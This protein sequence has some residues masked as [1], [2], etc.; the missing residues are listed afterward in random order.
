[1]QVVSESSVDIFVV[2]L[3]LIPQICIID[4]FY[5]GLVW[6]FFF[7]FHISANNPLFVFYC[8]CVVVLNISI[9][10]SYFAQVSYEAIKSDDSDYRDNYYMRFDNK[11]SEI[12]KKQKK[13]KSEDIDLNQDQ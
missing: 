1:M 8:S 5:I 10:A 11:Y 9:L 13:I 12:N 3:F 2:I 7:F 6:Y 4:A